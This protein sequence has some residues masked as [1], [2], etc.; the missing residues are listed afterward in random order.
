MVKM[1]IA[2]SCAMTNPIKNK[3]IV[4]PTIIGLG[5]VAAV[6][7]A[8]SPILAEAEPVWNHS[9]I[10]QIEGS[11]NVGDAM[12]SF[13]TE[14]KTV[15]FSDASSTA[16]AQVANGVVA[17][18]NIGVVQ[19][20]L[21]YTFFVVDSENNAGYKVVIDAGNGKVLHKSE[22]TSFKEMDGFSHKPFGFGHGSG[23]FCPFSKMM[24]HTTPESEDSDQD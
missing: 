23:G 7:A 2:Q 9:A 10:P 3:K 17:H 1:I 16:E 8:F 20:Y 15:K 11:V 13:I 21:V 24:S 22:G 19:G 6:L 4:I 5:F 14:H 12:K 18:G